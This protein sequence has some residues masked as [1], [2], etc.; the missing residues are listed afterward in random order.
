MRGK[1]EKGIWPGPMKLLFEF[2]GETR[3]LALNVLS[4]RSLEN[5][6]ESMSAEVQAGD[7]NLVFKVMRLNEITQEVSAIF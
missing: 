1:K 7:N 3:S 4:L 5:H 6:V 2:Q